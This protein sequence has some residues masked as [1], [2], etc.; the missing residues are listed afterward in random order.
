MRKQSTL[1]TE[2]TFIRYEPVM[3]SHISS[4]REDGRKTRAAA[5]LKEPDSSRI[6]AK[7]HH[8]IMILPP[9]G[10]SVRTTEG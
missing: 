1:T 7:I 10:S 5:G 2:Y 9:Q 3:R 8:S 6:K 4:E